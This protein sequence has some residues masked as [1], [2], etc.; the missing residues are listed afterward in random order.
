MTAIGDAPKLRGDLPAARPAVK[1]EHRPEPEAARSDAPVEVGT[2]PEISE[3][4]SAMGLA[5]DL[6]QRILGDQSLAI[7]AQAN[8]Q[9]EAIV[10]PLVA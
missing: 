8:R 2:K 6:H 9:E 7:A 3:Y 1:R 5:R 4:E 10:K